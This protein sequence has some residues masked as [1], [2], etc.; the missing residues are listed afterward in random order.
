M[1]YSAQRVPSS[2]VHS[3]ERGLTVKVRVTAHKI[4]ER[5]FSRSKKRLIYGALL[6]TVCYNAFDTQIRDQVS[7][8]FGSISLIDT[9]L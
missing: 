2:S 8:R 4:G 9:G 3:W 6:C 1:R 5:S 7:A